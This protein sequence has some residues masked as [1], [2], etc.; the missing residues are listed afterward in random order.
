MRAKYGE[1]LRRFLKE[2][3]S[4]INIIDFGGYPVFEATVDTNI[5]LLKKVIPISE[6][7]LIFVNVK[8]VNGDLIGYIENNKNTIYQ[9]KL[10]DNAWTLADDNILKIKEKI[11]KIGTPLEKWDVKIYRGIITGFNEA[12][13]ITTEKRKEILDACGSEDERKRTEEIIK[14]ILRGRDIGRYYY[15]WAGLWVIIV[16][17]GFWKELIHYPAIENH[18]MQY[19]K[20]LKNR[21]QCRYSR[22]GK[23]N[24]SNDY[25]GQHHWLE[26]DNNPSDIYLKE[27]EKE[28]IVWQRVTK[29]P[30]FCYVEKE[31]LIQDSMAF[32]FSDRVNYLLAILNSKVINI[33][34]EFIGHKYGNTG[35]LCS[36][37]YVK[38]FPIPLITKQNKNISKELESL[39]NKILAITKDEDYLQNHTKEKEVKEYERQID[40]M[41]YEL[42]NLTEEE[43]NIIETHSK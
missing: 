2:K 39:V 20:Q 12:F 34:F 13:I 4:V 21:G 24:T 31:I 28:K 41:V 29:N 40:Q 32:L 42:Y 9:N 6:H 14:P 19:E 11:E 1:K 22:V 33:F 25:S 7:K 16:K 23:I 36:N 37:Q 43:I 8:N 27:F 35:F 5:I 10:S 3:T 38:R 30:M 17:F 26:L 18:L 15:K